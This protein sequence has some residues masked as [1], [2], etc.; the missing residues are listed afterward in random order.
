MTQSPKRTQTSD[1][2]PDTPSG[3]DNQTK[4]ALVDTDKGPPKGA[5]DPLRKCIAS[6]ES[7]PQSE[8]VRFVLSPDG[9][10][11]PDIAG[12]LPG[13]GAWVSATKEAI[14]KAI[15][16][17]AFSRAFKSQVKTSETLAEQTHMLLERKCLD[18]L[19]FAKRAG[20]LILGFDQVRDTIRS[21]RPACI[22]EASD[23]AHDGR[24]KILSLVRG[25]HTRGGDVE[26][27]P[28]VGCFSANELGMAIGRQRVIHAIVKQGRFART[29]AVETARLAGF[30]PLAPDGWMSETDQ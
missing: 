11:T 21:S 8:M 22:V 16:Q 13:R 17:K 26:F 27:P 19:G 15:K 18:L 30:R 12:R 7:R 10:V 20:D 3:S 28:I 4:Q 24:D 6:G 5:S 2:R 25:V 1:P 29:F 9:N 23:G 14:E